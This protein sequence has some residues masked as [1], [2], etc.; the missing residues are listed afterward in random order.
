MTSIPGKQGNAVYFEEPE[1]K[2]PPLL[3]VG[4]LAWVKENLFGSVTDTILTIAGIVVVVSVITAFL[5]WAVTWANW[6]VVI[7]N[8][9][10]FLIGRFNPEAEWRIALLA[11]LIAF[12]V[13]WLLA[14]WARASR[15]MVTVLAII[16]VLTVVLPPLINQLVPASPSYMAAGT[17]EIVSGSVTQ[18]AAPQIAFIGQAGEAISVNVASEYGEDDAELA[19]IFSFTDN[20]V[21]ILRGA[22]EAR[23]AI[24][25]RI[26]EIQRKLEGDALTPNQREQL[27]AELEGL[28]VP[29]PVTE[30]YAINENPVEVTILDG[31]TLEPL[32]SAVLDVNGEPLDFTLPE[33][34]WYVLDKTVQGDGLS[35]IAA[36]GVYPMMER[37]FTRSASVSESGETI[38]ASRVSQ[39]I[40]MSDSFLIEGG[41]P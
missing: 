34:G 19:Q 21:N 18:T 39:Y 4:P 29:P 25:S 35:L 40:R 30:T 2:A 38:Q 12:L 9:R 23:L 17:E 27:T 28:D 3:A 1:T 13:G 5:T 8:L 14:A 37:N 7:F 41:R 26:P 10:Q 20:P 31:T 33:D 6:F 22:A 32:A 11:V 16:A 24:E 15:T 36:S